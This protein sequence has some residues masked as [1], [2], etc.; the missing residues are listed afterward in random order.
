[1]TTTKFK[2][3]KINLTEEEYA[4]VKA[5]A[6]KCGITV[7][8]LCRALLNRYHPKPLPDTA[9][10]ET[11]SQLYSLYAL[12]KADEAAAKLLHKT[13]LSFE[14]KALLPERGEKYGGYGLW[15]IKGRIDHLINYVEN[16]EKT[17]ADTAGDK[18]LQALWDIVGYTTRADKTEQKLFVSGINCLP[19]LAVTE[20]ILVKKQFRKEDGRLAYH[21]Y[22]SF[23]PG[24]VTPTQCHE[25]GLALAREMWGKKYQVVVS[26][27]LDKGHL[28]CHFAVNSV[29]FVDGLKYDRTTAEYA[30]MRSIADRLCRARSLSVIE[31]PSKTK[32]PR[33][34]YLAEKRGEPTRYNVYR[35]AIDKA[36]ENCI[37]P[38]V[39]KKRLEAQGFIVRMGD[40]RYY[41]TIN[42]LD[43][44][45]PT[46]FATLGEKYDERN[47]T[48]QMYANDRYYKPQTFVHA[49]LKPEPKRMQ[50]HGSLRDVKKLTGFR[51]LYFH[52]LYLLG[53]LPRS[54]PRPQPLNPI[55]YEDLR[56]MHIYSAQIKLLA[57]NKIDTSPQ[58]QAYKDNTQNRMDDLIGQRDK[59]R[60]KLRR[61]K[62]PAAVAD[63]QAQKSK[64]TAQ[65]VVCRN[66]IKL[67]N[68]IFEN[69]RR[70]Q[71]KIALYRAE[72]E[73]QAQQSKNKNRERGYAR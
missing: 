56:K 23:K 67:C 27:H 50:F 51:A 10:R 73:R 41:A 17:R 34:I 53:K 32:T 69:T 62:D 39:F 61:A 24:E 19:E 54:H 48:R 21:G 63:L 59:I 5:Y 20:M 42:I 8:D 57:V 13:I 60:N 4:T 7:T 64:L 37:S 46:R 38:Y 16:P 29:S 15:A 2:P 36:M 65:I 33:M 52:Y 58:L 6:K 3:I 55:F 25:I 31:N 66:E 40:K 26:T 28:H 47:L 43:G 18:D 68:G 1:M 70:M 44:K 30:R 12:I 49:A 22:L 35:A 9:F 14:K 71:E 72:Q 45:R 11:L